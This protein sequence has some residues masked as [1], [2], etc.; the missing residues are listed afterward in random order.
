MNFKKRE[1][2][3][4]GNYIP[5]YGTGYNTEY[6]E[7]TP[8]NYSNFGSEYTDRKKSTKKIMIALIAAVLLALII[9]AWLRSVYINSLCDDLI[10]T[11]KGSYF[12]TQGETGLTLT[13]Y[14][15]DKEYKALFDFY[16]LPGRTNA[17]SGKYY[18][19]VSYD[20]NT[21]EYSFDSIKWIDKPTTYYFVDL[22]GKLV[23]NILSGESPT[24]FSVTK[25]TNETVFISD[26]T[27]MLTVE[28]N[29][30]SD[31]FEHNGHHYKIYIDI[32]K[33]WEEAEE[34]CKNL[35]GH[36]AVI[37]SK[38]ENDALFSY[39]ISQGI[40][41]AYFGYS[42]KQKEGTWCWSGDDSSYTNWHKNEPNAERSNEDY[43]MFYWKFNDGT[44]NDGNFGQGT[45]SDN[46]NFI[47]EWD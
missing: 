5:N 36:L 44:W 20:I 11:Y 19:D 10:G 46:L 23:G 45:R 26:N 18:M 22:K 9:G 33:T 16:S 3:S 12:A 21:K 29:I 40:K 6:T 39:M 41:N 13:I 42:D 43:A 15:E 47:C 34:Y 7:N 28:K 25:I 1:K 37:S 24:K 27:T 35:G 31:A 38:E 17:K 4:G 2:K 14:K 30:P 8:M 32:C